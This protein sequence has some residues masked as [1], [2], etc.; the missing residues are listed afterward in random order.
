MM[1]DWEEWKKEKQYF[2][3]PG[4]RIIVGNNKEFN[5]LLDSFENDLWLIPFLNGYEP[6]REPHEKWNR[7]HIYKDEKINNVFLAYQL[8]YMYCK[9]NIKHGNENLGGVNANFYEYHGKLDVEEFIN[10]WAEESKAGCYK[11]F[12]KK[13]GNYY[14]FDDDLDLM[15]AMAEENNMSLEEMQKEILKSLKFNK[16]EI[17]YIFEELDI[18]Y[19]E[20]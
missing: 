5:A 13:I 2:F 4:E 10:Q 7:G 6:I 14:Y 3:L 1:K 15:R 8:G 19:Y 16:K 17:D 12:D 18:N 9:N 11:D 20:D